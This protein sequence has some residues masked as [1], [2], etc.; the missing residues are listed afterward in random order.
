ME[1]P[2]S[3]CGGKNQ[4]PV[5][6]QPKEAVRKAYP[7]FTF[8]NY[9]NIDQIGLVNSGS[10]GLFILFKFIYLY[11]ISNTDN[12]AV[13]ILYNDLF[14]VVHENEFSRNPSICVDVVKNCTISLSSVYRYI[15]RSI[16]MLIFLN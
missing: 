6:L 10:S 15:P 11:R 9:G 12:A 1:L 13:T 2:S 16:T 7:K 5:D 3:S 14:S 8:S 4:S